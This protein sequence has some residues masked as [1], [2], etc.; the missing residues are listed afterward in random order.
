MPA[1]RK[2]ANTRKPRGMKPGQKMV[3]SATRAGVIFGPARCNRQMRQ[4]RLSERQSA[5]AGAFMAAVLEY[6]T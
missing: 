4:M 3:S 1:G 2:S 5:S 6:L